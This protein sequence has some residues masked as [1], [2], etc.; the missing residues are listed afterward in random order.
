MEVAMP[1][2]DL[3][4]IG[5]NIGALYSLQS[6]LD[7]N[8]KLASTQQ[9]LSTGKRINSAADD[10]AGLV[11]A[12][13][14][15]ARSEGLRVV[16]DNISDATNMMS[17][18]EAGLNQVTDIV[19]Q[20]R[21]K[22]TQAANDTLGQTERAAIQTQLSQFS[23]QIDDI[24]KST[25]WNGTQLLSGALSKQFQTGVDMDETTTWNMNTNLTSGS[26]GLGLS[27]AVVQSTVTAEGVSI[28][29]SGTLG[30]LSELSTGDYTVS[31]EDKATSDIL[32]K[33]NLLSNN[34][35]M[36]LDHSSAQATATGANVMSS[37]QYALKITNVVSARIS[38][39]PS[40]KPATPALA[41][42]VCSRSIMPISITQA[43]LEA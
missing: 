19:T 34:S 12:T 27:K 42:T 24:L 2:I 10:P 38:A 35:S 13:K 3:T 43:P 11:I 36:T 21:S 25:K 29:A 41:P 20:M 30:N 26:G 37:G 31:A 33:T 40:P 18:A 4:R 7:I 22:A 28:P 17:V 32:G 8:N 6:L 16:E 5:S 39:T 15:H 1:T 23:A 9:R 14:M